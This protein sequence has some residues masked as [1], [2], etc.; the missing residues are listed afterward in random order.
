MSTSLIAGVSDFNLVGALLLPHDAC[1]LG[2]MKHPRVA[3]FVEGVRLHYSESKSEF[4][5]LSFFHR[6][7]HFNL[8]QIPPVLSDYNLGG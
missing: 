2:R 4:D 5:F 1:T 6:N 7:F 3:L 8:K